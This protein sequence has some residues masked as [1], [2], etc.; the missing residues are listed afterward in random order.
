MAQ[1]SNLNFEARS[2]LHG[3]ADTLYDNA[4]TTFVVYPVD[5]TGAIDLTDPQIR[6]ESFFTTAVS[7]SDRERVQY[8]MSS[9]A[10]KLYSFG[11]EHR[12]YNFSG[13]LFDTNI[14]HPI[15]STQTEVPRSWRGDGLASWT[16]FFENW[17]SLH[18]SSKRRTIVEVTYANRRLYGCLLQTAATQLA[19]QPHKVDQVF[20]FYVN[21]AVAL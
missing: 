15:E 21:Q 8:A 9:D 4:R 3:E 5:R 19:V 16:N 6:F 17:G 12:I 1:P 7:E 18:A 11:R 13:F 10:P 2:G 20:S 14:D